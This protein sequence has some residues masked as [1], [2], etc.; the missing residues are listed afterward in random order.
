MIIDMIGVMIVVGNS[1][2]RH[3]YMSPAGTNDNR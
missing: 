3:N 1:V 2:K